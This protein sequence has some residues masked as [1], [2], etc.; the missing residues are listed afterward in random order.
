MNWWRS[1]GNL[2]ARVTSM[3]L[4]GPEGA[5][6]WGGL[7]WKG[8]EAENLCVCQSVLNDAGGT[9]GRS[10]AGGTE[11]PVWLCLGLLPRW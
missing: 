5:S 9:G 6:V 3:C 7:V 11:Q 8:G 1:L 4:F 10:E 2:L